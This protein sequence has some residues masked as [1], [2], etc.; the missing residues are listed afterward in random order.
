MTKG[1]YKWLDVLY[2]A[3]FQKSVGTESEGLCAYLEDTG[4]QVAA[5]RWIRDLVL[6]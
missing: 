3:I 1:N 4:G 2:R 5:Y 6:W